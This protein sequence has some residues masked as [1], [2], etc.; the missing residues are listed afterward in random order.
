VGW[1]KG[2][3][4]LSKLKT[5]VY[6]LT[7]ALI[8][9]FASIAHAQPDQLLSRERLDVWGT[10]DGLPPQ[11]VGA[12]VQTPDG[13][14]WLGTA[15]GL[16]RFDGQ[17]FTLYDSHNTPSLTSS[18]I[19]TLGVAP[20]GTLWVG[21]EWAGF[22]TFK[23]G[24]YHRVS[25]ADPRWNVTNSFYFDTDGSVWVGAHGTEA[26]YHVVDGIAHPILPLDERD[27]T[28]VTG[29]IRD[30]KDSILCGVQGDGV[31]RLRNDGK[32]LPWPLNKELPTVFVKCML[33]DSHG[34][35]WLGTD[36]SG[37]GRVHNGTLKTYRQS[38]GLPA[39]S[40]QTICEDRA[41]NLWI[42]TM[43]GIGRWDG[44]RFSQFGKA[45]GLSASTV[46]TISEDREGNLWVG[47]GGGLDRF[48]ITKVVPIKIQLGTELAYID[49]V[50]PRTVGQ[51]G[52]SD[53]GVWLATSKGLWTV[54]SDGYDPKQMKALEGREISGVA[55]AADGS[56]WCWSPPY[57]N[58]SALYH[59]SG[60]KTSTVYVDPQVQCAVPDGPNA[61]LFAREKM[62][63][64]DGHTV[65][66]PFA[67]DAGG[68][69]FVAAM[70]Q[71]KTIWLGTNN[72]LVKVN[73][74]QSRIVDTGQPHGTHVLSVD[75]DVDGSLW[76]GS[77]HGLIH[78]VNGKA[79][80]FQV[81]D[82]LPDANLFEV[83]STA[84]S[85]W[86]GDHSGLFAIRK[87]DLLRHV[88]GK[89]GP[90]PV[91]SFAA[92]DG[93]LSAPIGFTY[94]KSKN[95][96]LW[97]YGTTAVMHADI[98]HMPVNMQ[99]P[100]VSILR[101]AVDGK[102]LAISSTPSASTVTRAPAGPGRLEIQYAA[103][104]FVAPERVRF[105]YRL[106]GFDTHWI[107]A[108]G[109]RSATYTNLAPGRYLFQV[110]ACNNDGVWNWDGAT[111]AF[112]IAPHF[113]QTLWFRAFACVGFV[114]LILIVLKVCTR[115]LAQRARRLEAVVR[116]RTADLLSANE[117]LSDAHQEL[118]AQNDLLQ[119]AQ[120]EL[121]VQNEELAD[122]QAELEAQNQELSDTQIELEHAN[123]QLQE[124]ATT[125]GL[126]GLKNHRSFR[127]QL[128]YEW[129]RVVRTQ[130]PLSVILM[131]VDRFKQY[132][133]TYGHP[134]G[135]DVLRTVASIL[136]AQARQGD[137]V[138]RY[139]G[140]EFVVL[141]PNTDMEASTAVAER[142]RAEI[143]K[144]GWTLREV[145]A[146][147]GVVTTSMSITSADELVQ[148]ADKCLY[149]SKEGGRNRVT[150]HNATVP[151]PRDKAA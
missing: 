147:F 83:M 130:Q 114:G 76:L 61:I 20:D 113:Y 120:A 62:Y 123:R 81:S 16:L 139:G 104:S 11:N 87:A 119:N 96:G 140:E 101:A 102:Q 88:S 49:N 116:E 67:V 112:E 8:V 106:Q 99:A 132:N 42:G 136:K 73:G 117:K 122:M 34:D 131:D 37:L 110:A 19:S 118:A 115:Q 2:Y 59:V 107:D 26:L 10:K 39:N 150:H 29:I 43:N 44:K 32:R 57:Q 4:K 47:S 90:I 7:F 54:S 137:F 18:L 92:S 91:I 25:N 138:A 125:D 9:V 66:G 70:D 149:V 84:D 60:G 15:S 143:E 48:G 17:N 141:L 134:A 31:W 82:G 30:S 97:F 94:A 65:T 145:T 98:G 135:D 53:P 22:G 78:Y 46:Q 105:R 14:I 146:S 56:V 126:T 3:R 6:L 95:G 1:F 103:M 74:T 133:D 80:A 86:C 100:P 40:I 127:E 64:T 68:Y 109:R 28:D 148:G 85:V 50:A 5:T 24:V 144:Y 75:V 13:F 129:A 111:V 38:D 128:D 12:I 52:K 71:N 41:G 79:R 35:I 33:R 23:D 72:G 121:E 77:D 63:R 51:P 58:R 89:S 27:T 21:I 142:F 93:V 108:G 69:V 36:N 124:L 55:S 45:D 151:N